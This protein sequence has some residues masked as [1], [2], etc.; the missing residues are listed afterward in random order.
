MPRTKQ[1]STREE[2]ELMKLSQ[3]SCGGGRFYHDG[4][5]TMTAPVPACASPSP[6]A[7][8]VTPLRSSRKRRAAI[9]PSEETPPSKKANEQPDFPDL[10]LELETEEDM[11]ETT[12]DKDSTNEYNLLIPLLSIT[13]EL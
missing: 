3:F 6:T 5:A 7:L 2:R 13:I 1:G 12:K 4:V 10:D 9:S 11:D 8:S